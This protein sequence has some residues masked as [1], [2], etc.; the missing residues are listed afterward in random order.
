MAVTLKSF[1]DEGKAITNEA[2]EAIEE[3]IKAGEHG[4]AA[5]IVQVPVDQLR[6][7]PDINPADRV[8][9]AGG[10]ESLALSI[11]T[12][13]LQEPIA[14][15]KDGKTYV[16]LRGH[17]RH[18]A[19]EHAIKEFGLPADTKWNIAV[20]EKQDAKTSAIDTLASNSG[21]GHSPL[22]LGELFQRAKD[23]GYSNAYIARANDVSPATVT[24][25]LKLWALPKAIR[26]YVADGEL[27][28]DDAVNGKRMVEKAAKG[29]D[30]TT[31]Q[32]KALACQN[33]FKLAHAAASERAGDG[34]SPRIRKA[35]IKLVI[36]T[37]LGVQPDAEKVKVDWPA[38]VEQALDCLDVDHEAYAI[39]GKALDQHNGAKAKPDTDS[40]TNA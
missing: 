16:I 3:T 37:I 33:V 11:F 7:N 1:D 29:K 9:N 10:I 30:V 20:V 32:K 23:D 8:K 31:A 24:N 6:V 38:I 35:D 2:G 39:L 34:A 25:W 40:D 18:A 14:A 21:K 22:E 15:Y 13:G 28:P 36:D 12:R 4:K 27:G 17:R 26:Q 5:N 19:I